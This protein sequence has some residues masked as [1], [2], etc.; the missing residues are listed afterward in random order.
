MATSTV[1]TFS[2]QLDAY[3]VSVT[4]TSPGDCAETI[5][6][7]VEQP[8]I[9]VPLP[10]ENASLPDVVETDPTAADLRAAHTGVT[11]GALGIAEY[12]SVLIETTPAGTE[13]VSLFNS[14]HIVVLRE[15][16]LVDEMRTAI[17]WLGP[18]AR[19]DDTSVI[20]ATGPSATADMGSL[21][22]GA[23]GPESVHVVLLAAGESDE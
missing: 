13:P 10:F 14:Q 3:N 21:V 8:A 17:E 6:D 2:S 19:D 15:S 4:R 22:Q 18:R 1:E 7:L 16:D 20:V 5:A 12:G 23:H 11:A 9:G